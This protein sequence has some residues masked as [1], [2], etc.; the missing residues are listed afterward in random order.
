[1]HP[2]TKNT[3]KYFPSSLKSGTPCSCLNAAVQKTRGATAERKPV[4]FGAVAQTCGKKRLWGRLLYREKKGG[5]GGWSQSL[6][7]QKWFGRTCV[8]STRTN[9]PLKCE[10]R[11][12]KWTVLICRAEY[13]VRAEMTHC[14]I[15]FVTLCSLLHLNQLLLTALRR[16]HSSSSPRST[17][18]FPPQVLQTPH[19]KR[20]RQR[21]GGRLQVLMK[22][23][24]FHPA[25]SRDLHRAPKC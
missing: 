2:R 17:S 6:N 4:L 3:Q 23:A 19:Q 22:S 8:R 14:E 20:D 12:H 7:M 9:R 25:V 10:N 18:S 11:R 21:L 16:P 5:G 15:L 13:S 24:R 1:M